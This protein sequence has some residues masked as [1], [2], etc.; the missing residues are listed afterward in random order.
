MHVRNWCLVES[1]LSFLCVAKL[2]TRPLAATYLSLMA[3][4]ESQIAGVIIA[5]AERL[6]SRESYTRGD[7][8]PR[9]EVVSS[10]QFQ[11]R[12]MKKRDDSS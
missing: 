2:H 7:E 11:R 10:R 4:V 1:R 6:D 3:K 8:H 12:Q 9:I 5:V